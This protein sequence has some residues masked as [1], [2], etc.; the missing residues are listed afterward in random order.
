MHIPIIKTPGNVNALCFR[1]MECEGNA[2]SFSLFSICSNEVTFIMIQ[3]I[4]FLVCRRTNNYFVTLFIKKRVIFFADK[5]LPIKPG[6]FLHVTKCLPKT[7]LKW[8]P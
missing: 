3:Q 5:D 4:V 7:F 6:W 2:F 8:N 1:R